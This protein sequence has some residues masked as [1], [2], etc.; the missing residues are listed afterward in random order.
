[1]SFV[2]GKKDSVGLTPF[3]S[4]A[5]F[6]TF[7]HDGEIYLKLTAS[8]AVCLFATYRAPRGFSWP[9]SIRRVTVSCE[10]IEG[11]TD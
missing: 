4:I 1:M 11:I 7:K 8:S 2:L 6:E 3:G 10:I 9:D 5:L